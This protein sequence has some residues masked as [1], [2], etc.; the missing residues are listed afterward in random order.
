M[1]VFVTGGTGFIGTAVV[2]ELMGAG[3]EVLGLAR[4]DASEAALLRAGAAVLR[5]TLTAPDVLTAGASRSDG[6]V[7]LGAAYTEASFADAA[8]LDRNALSAL[9]SAL[10]GTDRPLVVAS[11]T[12]MIAPGR[13]VTERD[14][15]DVT[16]ETSRGRAEAEVLAL[17]ERGVRVAVVRLA[18][19]VHGEED[20]RGFLPMLVEMARKRGVS[21]YVGDGRNRWPGVHQRD[22]ARLFR[23]AVEGV[24]AGSRLHAIADEGVAFRDIAAAIGGGLG[25]PVASI[26][27]EEA[28]DHFFLLGGPLAALTGLDIS[29]SST[30]T[31]QLLG[32]EATCPDVLTDL[33]AGFYFRR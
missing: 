30:L 7:H 9:G 8:A 10:E 3:H 24:P 23:L 12:S 32:W 33:E 4:S 29:A 28:G 16:A 5:G 13:L 2:R 19:V 15:G 1:R 20:T 31:R 27:A 11:A 14:T 18:T 6:V 22:A 25:V 26:A 17:A 21:A